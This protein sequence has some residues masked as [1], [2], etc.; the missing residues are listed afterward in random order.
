MSTGAFDPGKATPQV[1]KLKDKVR[2]LGEPMKTGLDPKLLEKD[3]TGVGWEL[4]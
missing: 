3:L 4:R 2:L 1:Q